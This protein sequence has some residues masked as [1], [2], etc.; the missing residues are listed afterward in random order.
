MSAQLIDSTTDHSRD[1]AE[2]VQQ[3]GRLSAQ[4]LEAFDRLQTVR[5]LLV[6][7]PEDRPERQRSPGWVGMTAN[8]VADGDP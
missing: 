3:A 5:R 4:R 7:L 1:G 2:V 8:R 6:R